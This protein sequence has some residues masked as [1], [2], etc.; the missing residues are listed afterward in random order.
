MH[1]PGFIPDERYMAHADLTVVFEQTYQT[2]MNMTA[3]RQLEDLNYNRHNLVSIMHSIP[4][5]PAESVK[6]LVNHLRLLTGH[7]FLTT[8]VNEYYH[9]FSPQFGNFVKLMS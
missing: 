3:A 9:S 8:L 4:E 2:W 7:V 6:C 5:L 1:N